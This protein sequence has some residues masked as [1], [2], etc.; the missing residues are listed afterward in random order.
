MSHAPA[1]L[2]EEGAPTFHVHTRYIPHPDPSI[3]ALHALLCSPAPSDAVD[4]PVCTPSHST[5]AHVLLCLLR[6]CDRQQCGP[7]CGVH[8]RGCDE[9]MGELPPH[10]LTD[11]IRHQ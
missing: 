5:S 3:A 10:L 8:Q 2:H 4:L 1:M 9:C 7:M 11:K 6:L